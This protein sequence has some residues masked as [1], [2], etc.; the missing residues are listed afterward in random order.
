MANRNCDFDFDF[1]PA[2]GLEFD[3]DIDRPFEIERPD[4]PSPDPLSD[5]DE[6][7]D[8]LPR[9]EMETLDQMIFDLEVERLSQITLTEEEENAIDAEFNRREW[10]AK[11]DSDIHHYNWFGKGIYHSSS[12][13]PEQSLAVIMSDPKVPEATDNLRITSIL[14]RA[15]LYLDP[16][17]VEFDVPDPNVL[18]N[19]LLERSNLARIMKGHVVKYYTP[20]GLWMSEGRPMADRIDV[21]DGNIVNYV[22][23][24]GVGNGFVTRSYINSWEQW[25]ANSKRKPSEVKEAARGHGYKKLTRRPRPSPLRQCMAVEA[26]RVPFHHADN[27]SRDFNH[28]G[29][30]P[31]NAD[32][33]ESILGDDYSKTSTET[34]TYYSFPFPE[35]ERRGQGVKHAIQKASKSV[36][37]C[38]RCG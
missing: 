17:V 38:L 15:Y 16:I 34:D 9:S 11:V 5:D 33:Y 3:I 7:Q 19:H 13:P 36:L 23:N 30:F 4:T 37:S 26:E 8:Y 20:H 21:D 29:E 22:L 27:P 35:P 32:R 28:N 1:G 31:S 14:N 10:L 18:I 6:D 24:H 25:Q 2:F 12:T